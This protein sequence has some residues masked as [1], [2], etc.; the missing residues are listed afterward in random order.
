[1][2]SSSCGALRRRFQISAAPGLDD[3][4]R[5]GFELGAFFDQVEAPVTAAVFALADQRD[6]LIER[7]RPHREMLDGTVS[8]TGAAVRF[9]EKQ[10]HDNLRRENSMARFYGQLPWHRFDLRQSPVDMARRRRLPL[11]CQL[12]PQ[13]S[14]V[15][16]LV[17]DLLARQL[18]I[19][20]R[21]VRLGKERAQPVGCE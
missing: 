18:E 2:G 14:E 21:P 3:G 11:I 6:R 15:G 13:L 5:A 4:R 9:D 19:R 12:L 10:F 16:H 17:L 1:M 8:T 7:V 20:H